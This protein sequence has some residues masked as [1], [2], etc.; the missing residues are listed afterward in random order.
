MQLEM[1]LQG[2]LLFYLMR[3]L[4]VNAVYIYISDLV[5]IY[6]NMNIFVHTLT[7]IVFK[8]SLNIV[9]IDFVISNPMTANYSKEP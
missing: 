5:V 1:Y 4:Q 2:C 6:K 8:N 9:D 7:P 3:D